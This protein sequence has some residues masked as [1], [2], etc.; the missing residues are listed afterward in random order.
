MEKFADLIVHLDDFIG[1]KGASQAD[2]ISAEEKLGVKFSPDYREYLEKYGLASF[3][4]YELTGIGNIEYLD[5]VS[6]TLQERE[7]L[8]NAIADELYVV[9]NPHID[10]IIIWQN[11]SGDI[12]KTIPPGFKRKIADSIL[13]YINL[14]L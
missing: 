5:V 6:V 7:I 11:S 13:E 8:D 12:F 3:K 1:G 9:D 14:N 2:I 4:Y 10:G